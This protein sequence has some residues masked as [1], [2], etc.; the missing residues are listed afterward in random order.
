MKR[1]CICNIPESPAY[2]V[3]ISQL[4][5]YA[6]ACSS[7]CDFIYRGKAL[8]TK[9]VEQGYVKNRLKV[10]GRKFYGRYNDLVRSYNV[11]LTQFLGDLSL[12]YYSHFWL[13]ANRIGGWSSWDNMAGAWPQ[14]DE[15][16]LPG[17]LS[18]LSIYSRVHVVSSP[19]I[20]PNLVTIF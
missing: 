9:L 4:I 8:T 19:T 14:Q 20:F 1:K 7:Y 3:Y 5:R 18:S 13:V 15:F 11:S 10:Y 12:W 16:T 17:H 6:R 2:G